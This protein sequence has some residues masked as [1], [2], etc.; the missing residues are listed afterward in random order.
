MKN[1]FLLLAL[2]TFTFSSCSSS[3][4]DGGS[5]GNVTSPF[6]GRWSGTYSGEFQGVWHMDISS[7]GRLSGT[8]EESTSGYIATITS[9][10]V[11]ADGAMSANYSNGG[12]S[13]GQIN[14]TS[15]GGTWV[16]GT[17]SGDFSGSKE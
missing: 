10:S 6:E 9:G 4:D 14:G 12:S 8:F 17:S 2:I 7:T 13:S 5:S 15:I 16:Q 11:T 3:D 1:L